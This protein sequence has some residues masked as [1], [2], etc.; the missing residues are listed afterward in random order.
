MDLNLL[1]VESARHAVAARQITASALAE[2]FYQKI[3]AEDGAIHAYLTLARE[4]ALQQAERIDALVARGEALPPLAGVPIAIKDVIVHARRAHHL[5]LED[6][7]GLHPA[8]RR[9]RR[10]AAGSGRG[11][12]PRQ[13]QLR[14]VRHGLVHRE[15]RL[16]PDAQPVGP[17]RVP[18]GSS[19]GSAAAVAA[20]TAV[21]A[22]GTDTGGSIRQPAAFCG[23]V[24]LKPTYGRVSRYGL[25]A[26]ASSLDQ[27]RP[28]GP[29]G[30]RLPPCSCGALPATTRWTPP[31]RTL[32][33]P[34]Y[35][36]GAGATGARAAHG[37][38]RRVLRRRTRRGSA[39]R[40]RSAASSGWPQLGCEVVPISLPHTRLRHRRPTT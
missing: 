33:V 35:D 13:D 17:D 24:G 30:G 6:S 1:T 32:P 5:R 4:R 21:A 18:G 38:P 40:G 7:R 27:H 3:A 36:A 14:R 19:G 26:F 29:H 28:A 12:G 8:L 22:L 25:I 16:R 9:H 39:Q 37:R 31:R 11:G 20:G 10:G 23:V 2:S 15:L 34:D